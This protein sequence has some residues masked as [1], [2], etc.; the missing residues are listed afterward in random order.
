MTCNLNNE[1]FLAFLNS[2]K[3]EKNMKMTKKEILDYT[4][5]HSNT[6]EL[7]ALMKKKELTLRELKT[8]NNKCKGMINLELSGGIEIR[9]NKIF[10]QLDFSKSY[11]DLRNCIPNTEADLKNKI[12]WHSHP[13]NI[14]IDYNNNVP[15]FFSFEDISISAR[16]PEHIFVVFNMSCKNPKLP[17]I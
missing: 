16:F 5:Y 8:L 2:R 3:G 14:S 6:K 12:I 13:W 7:K 1:K 4:T 15:N 10:V 17:L 9:N 11:F